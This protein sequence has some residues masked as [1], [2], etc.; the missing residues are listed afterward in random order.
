MK[1]I[2]CSVL[3]M[4]LSSSAMAFGPAYQK[5]VIYQPQIIWEPSQQTFYVPQK[6]VV[7]QPRTVYTPQVV[8]ERV[9]CPEL[10]EL[11]AAICDKID[12]ILRLPQSIIREKH[13]NK[14]C[15][16]YIRYEK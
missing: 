16:C 7:Y 2:L 14:G 13:C 12:C 3:L 1:W 9:W 15:R 8:V 4:A 6:R 11:K 5:R 10:N